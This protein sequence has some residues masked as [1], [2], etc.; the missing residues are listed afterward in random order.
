MKYG[1]A[2][3]LMMILEKSI[4]H[5]DF[6]EVDHHKSVG[7]LADGASWSI[8]VDTG[9]PVGSTVLGVTATGTGETTLVGGSFIVDMESLLSRSVTND[10][11]I[12][13][14][15]FLFV[16]QLIWSFVVMKTYEGS[17]LGFNP[18]AS[19]ELLTPVEG[20]IELACLININKQLLNSCNK[21]TSRV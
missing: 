6:R 2:A 15:R 16:N 3:H 11:E 1:M 5:E 12:R 19:E 4:L 13:Q 17:V 20:D 14:I 8:K 21:L 18:Q 7:L 9:E 10:M